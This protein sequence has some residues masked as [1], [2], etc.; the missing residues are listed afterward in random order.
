MIKKIIQRGSKQ[1]KRGKCIICD[2]DVY[3][4]VNMQPCGQTIKPSFYKC[5]EC[6]LYGSNHLWDD[7]WY[8]H[9]LKKENQELKEKI[10]GKSN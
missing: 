6:G 5:S 1:I 2:G 9:K 7:A 3:E 8:A 10:N 4:E